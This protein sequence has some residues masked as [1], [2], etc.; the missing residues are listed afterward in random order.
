MHNT[1]AAGSDTQRLPGRRL[2]RA[3]L[4]G[5]LSYVLLVLPSVAGM[6]GRGPLARF[7]GPHPHSNVVVV[8]AADTV[9]RAT[10]YVEP[11]KEVDT[12]PE[13]RFTELL[14]LVAMPALLI[15]ASLRWLLWKP[16]PG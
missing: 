15:G 2:A 3:W 9:R 13:V 8:M 6:E 11:S 7:L 1:S 4:F 12:V 5:G 10:H 14:L 16:A